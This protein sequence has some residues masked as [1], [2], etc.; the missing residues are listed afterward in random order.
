M[1]NNAITRKMNS[2]T[3]ILKDRLENFREY[4]NG[5]R[6]TEKENDRHEKL[7][8]KTFLQFYQKKIQAVNNF[9][10]KLNRF[11]SKVYHARVTLKWNYRE[12]DILYYNTGRLNVSFFSDNGENI[13]LSIFA[14]IVFEE[15]EDTKVDKL[16]LKIPKINMDSPD[17]LELGKKYRKNLSNEITIY[18]QEYD[19]YEAVRNDRNIVQY[20]T[21]EIK[22]SALEDRNKEKKE[23]EKK[24]EDLEKIIQ[25]KKNNSIPLFILRKNMQLKIQ[26]R[27]EWLNGEVLNEVLDHPD[28]GYFM[29]VNDEFHENYIYEELEVFADVLVKNIGFSKAFV[30]VDGI[31]VFLDDKK[32]ESK[33]IDREKAKNNSKIY[34]DPTE[35]PLYQLS[36]EEDEE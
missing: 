9:N 12:S 25:R 18:D 4:F 23:K 36:L 28:T 7:D 35:D 21:M 27:S 14:K 11:T 5:C 17:F 33:P 13:L 3:G 26:E 32:E 10:C 30:E 34:D 16:I 20:E 8:T 6:N 15:G 1:E 19:F 22:A 31:R 2:I 24:K 29:N